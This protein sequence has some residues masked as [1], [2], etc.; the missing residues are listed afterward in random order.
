MANSIFP[1]EAITPQPRQATGPVAFG[2]SWKFNF[3]AG[4]F[5]LTPTGRQTETHDTDAWFEWVKKAVQTQRYRFIIY[6]RRYGEEQS[7]LI[8]KSLP[9]AVAES[10]IRRMVRE[11]LLCDERTAK[12]EKF[13]FAWDPDHDAVQYSCE[14]SNKRGQTRNVSGKVEIT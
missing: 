1:T 6:S 7:T 10:E 4:D 12:V 5:V 11:C 14:V 3:E 9:M 13:T 8:A 2:R